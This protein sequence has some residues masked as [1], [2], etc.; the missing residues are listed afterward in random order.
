[1]FFFISF[2]SQ[3]LLFFSMIICSFICFIFLYFSI[4]LYQICLFY[5]ALWFKCVV[6]FNFYN[7]HL[8]VLCVLWFSLLMNCLPSSLLV[9]N[10]YTWVYNHIYQ[11]LFLQ[12][13][14]LLP[15][16]VFYNLDELCLCWEHITKDFMTIFI[17]YQERKK[18]IVKNV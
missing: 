12:C 16:K 11:Q 9:C 5:S 2:P 10:F 18:M 6:F 3:I 17:K 15:V 1:M 8:Q 14:S 13:P 4:S 7:V